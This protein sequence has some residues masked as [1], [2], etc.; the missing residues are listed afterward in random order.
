MNRVGTSGRITFI[1]L[2]SQFLLIFYFFTFYLVDYFYN[3]L[4]EISISWISLDDILI[5]QF[6]LL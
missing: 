6:S 3:Y 2:L 1:C 5:K 4:I